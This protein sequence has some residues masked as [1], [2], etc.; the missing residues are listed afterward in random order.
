MEYERFAEL[1]RQLYLA[2]QHLNLPEQESSPSGEI[3]AASS[4]GDNPGIGMQVAQGRSMLP[5]QWVRQ[6]PTDE[7]RRC[8]PDPSISEE[9]GVPGSMLTTPRG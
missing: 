2:F 6:Y 7:S 5:A 9:R 1:F 3:H 8:K 4:Y